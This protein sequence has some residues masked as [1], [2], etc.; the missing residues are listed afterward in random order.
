MYG[1]SD[2]LSDTPF[3][4]EDPISYIFARGVVGTGGHRPSTKAGLCV[5][6]ILDLIYLYWLLVNRDNLTKRMLME[7]N[8]S[9]YCVLGRTC[10]FG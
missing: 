7:K 6:Y 2:P 9:C 4:E 3:G 8:V 1:S 5:S 10:D